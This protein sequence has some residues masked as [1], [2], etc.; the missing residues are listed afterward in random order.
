MYI[1]F[2]D[3]DHWQPF[4]L[5]LP[6]VPITDLTIKNNNL[7]AATQGR[8]FWI[9]D[10]L[11]LIH[12]LPKSPPVSF[13]VYQPADSYRFQGYAYKSLGEGTNY[14]GG[15][16]V[17]Y[18][19]PDSLGKKDTLSIT[20]FEN[21]GDTI[22]SFSTVAADKAFL[23][24]PRKGMNKFNWS[25]SYP[26]SKSFDGM[27]LWAGGLSGPRAIPGQYAV[28]FKLNDTVHRKTFTVL[29]DPRSVATEE[30]Y[31]KYYDFVTDIRDKVS[32]A[33]EA[34]IEI[35]DIRQQLNNYTSR[36]KEDTVLVKEA[37]QIDS[38]MTRI[39]EALYQTKIRSVQ[40]PLNYPVRLTNKLAYLNTLIGDGEYPPT[41]QA[42]VVKDELEKQIDAEL[43]KFEQVKSEMIPAFNRMIRTK[44]IDA[45]L[46]KKK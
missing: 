32:D 21:S 16:V 7:I 41:D 5:N 27:M 4:Q 12:Q 19:L 23:I 46:L 31:R 42:Y 36:V 15:L 22:S 20:L 38:I 44:E 25:L 2:D 18:F 29:K 1:S 10:D 13:H 14:A 17:N 3:G 45:I 33:H 24:K 30:D 9:I 6:I 11:A 26:P 43:V 28:E 37:Q 35:R 34:I 40:D 39:E 8:S